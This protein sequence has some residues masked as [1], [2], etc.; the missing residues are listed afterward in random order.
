LPRIDISYDEAKRLKTLSE[1]GLDFRDASA[2]FASFHLTRAD[3]RFDYGEMRFITVGVLGETV[4]V[5]VWT[6]RDGNR[7][8]ISMRKADRDERRDYDRRRLDRSG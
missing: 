2:I 4:V 6:E 8:I 3:D 7:R 5:M 1:R